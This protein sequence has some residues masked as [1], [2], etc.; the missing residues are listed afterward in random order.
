MFGARSQTDWLYIT[1]RIVTINLICLIVENILSNHE[2]GNH[3]IDAKFK[4]KPE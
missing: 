3:C 2:K 1:G 4:D